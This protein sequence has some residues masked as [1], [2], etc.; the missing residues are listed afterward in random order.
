QE[1]VMRFPVAVDS[2]GGKERWQR[3]SQ[4]CR[5]GGQALCVPNRGGKAPSSG[6]G[7]YLSCLAASMVGWEVSLRREPDRDDAG[8]EAQL[9]VRMRPLSPKKIRGEM[10]QS[11]AQLEKPEGHPGQKVNVVVIDDK[12]EVA[13]Y[14]WRELGG[15]PGFGS[16]EDEGAKAR[17]IFELPKPIET[18]DQEIAVWWVP[19]EGDFRKRLS[20]VIRRLPQETVVYFLVD[21]RGPVGSAQDGARVYKWEN[22]VKQIRRTSSDVYPE[23][24]RLISSYEHGI[25]TLDAYPFEIHDKSPRTFSKLREE[26]LGSHRTESKEE[27]DT[28]HILVTG[29]GFEMR[30]EPEEQRL[31]TPGTWDLLERWI[32]NFYGENKLK[33]TKGFSIPAD[34]DDIRWQKL[35]NA[36]EASNLDEYWTYLLEAERERTEGDGLAKA[37]REYELRESFRREFVRFDWGYLP[38]AIAAARLR[39]SVW[40]STNYTRF[41]DR[42]LE[43]ASRLAKEQ[44]FCPWRTIE[45]SEEAERL[46]RQVLHD[47]GRS[48]LD[49]ERILVK[50]HGDISHVLT[51]AIAG[52]D[53]SFLSR[54]SSFAPLYLAAQA[55][56]A[57]RA[58]K[59]TKITWHIVGHGLRDELL[60]R[61]IETVYRVKPKK[62]RF[63]VVDPAKGGED[64]QSLDEHP[65]YRLARKLGNLGNNKNPLSIIDAR[66]ATAG[67][68]LT[69][70]ERQGLASFETVLANLDRPTGWPVGQER[71]S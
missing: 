29:A 40:L 28:I 25:R 57:K 70:L 15:V 32:K 63:V 59:A 66:C 14:T 42:A 58:L 4:A 22:A 54:L 34:L 6:V 23:R 8:K 10:D 3:L 20:R 49:K 52:E 43:R 7:L 11:K 26:F 27:N 38:Q 37:Q 50:L 71:S 13:L 46:S 51:M 64:P 24:I 39:W 17:K 68:Y 62:H 55:A 60:L 16:A 47:G 33:Q 2:E 31:G 1:L 69:K 48:N 41:A 36:A 35:R 65:G 53:K 56:L 44:E 12:I 5:L 61:V 30:E 67:L 21:V 45:V 9:L 19:A 18:P